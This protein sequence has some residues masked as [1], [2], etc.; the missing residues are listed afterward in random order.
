MAKRFVSIW[1]RYLTTDWLTRRK[2]ELKNIPFV[3]AAPERG[4][5]VVKAVNPI[6]S[7]N[8]IS[9]GMVVA[10]GRA[11]L[12][13]LQVFDDQHGKDVTLLTAIAEWCIRYTPIAAIDPPDGLILDVSGCTHLW[14]SELQY[15]K[16]LLGRLSAFG[17]SVRP[18]MADTIGCAWAIARFGLSNPVIESGKQVEALNLLPPAALRLETSTNERLNKLGLIEI[19]KFMTMPRSALRRRFGQ[20]LL[21]RLDQAL[22]QEIEVLVPVK[23]IEPYQERLPSLE[24]VRTAQA[25]EYALQELL[26][27][28]CQRLTAEEKGIRKAVF[29][30]YRIDN[31]IQSIDIGTAKASRNAMHLFRL[32]EIKIGQ[33][34]P[35]LGIEL[36]VLEATVVEHLSSNQEAIW[37]FSYNRQKEL[38][39]LL[40]RIAVK[41]GMHTIHR[42]LPDEHHWPERSFKEAKS[43]EEE[44]TTTWQDDLPRP[45]HL[46]RDPEL[47]EVTVAMPDY[48]PM[49]FKHKGNLYRVKKADGPERIEQE[50]WIEQGLYRDYYCV[51][52][53]KGARY[54]LFR[55]GHYLN[56]EPKWFIH[57]F[58]A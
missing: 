11:I 39:E 21:S 41:V 12:P 16:D 1:F 5:M 6:A 26:D 47:I 38:A 25:I 7:A 46:L 20:S 15:L 53:D 55:L 35:A 52:D 43:L 57:G 24:P 13:S 23:P 22:G 18:G 37:N 33:I 27:K 54:W 32:F 31:N 14:G 10:D 44:A 19:G 29:K 9:P 48:P 3:F 40:D 28:I 58:F 34:M 4:R 51:E 36:F 17:Y 50:W 49:L 56:H 42:Y 30:C 8:G 45:V 2:P